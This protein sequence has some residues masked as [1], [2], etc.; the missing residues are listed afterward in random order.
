M[1]KITQ[2]KLAGA[3]CL[4]WAPLDLQLIIEKKWVWV[5]SCN[6]ACNVNGL[7]KPKIRLSWA[8]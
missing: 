6:D 4:P 1:H 2:A 7:D 5:S 3:N 8:K